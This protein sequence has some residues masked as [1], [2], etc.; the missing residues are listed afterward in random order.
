MVAIGS[1]QRALERF[2]RAL[3]HFSPRSNRAKYRPTPWPL[4]RDLERQVRGLSRLMPLVS[5]PGD[6][7]VQAQRDTAKRSRPPAMASGRRLIHTRQ[8]AKTRAPHN[9]TCLECGAEYFA[10]HRDQAPEEMPSCCQCGE[11]FLAMQNGR[12]MHYQATSDIVL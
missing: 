10:T 5:E 7:A 6:K 9:Y 3:L 11:P 12:Y 8:M 4:E 1:F 2:Y